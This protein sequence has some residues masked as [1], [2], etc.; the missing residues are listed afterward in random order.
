VQLVYLEVSDPAPGGESYRRKIGSKG[1]MGDAEYIKPLPLLQEVQDPQTL[2]I[3]AMETA[4]E[5]LSPAG[6]ICVCADTQNSARVRLVLDDI[7]GEGNFLNEVIWHFRKRGSSKKRFS[8]RHAALF[9]YGK[10][11]E[12]KFK[13][14]GQVR[15]REAVHH[16][17]RNID[18]EGRVYF[19]LIS[20]GKEYKYY[21]D[22]IIPFDD[23]WDIP[24]EEQNYEFALPGQKPDEL[25]KRIIFASTD[26][27][28]KVAALFAGA[29]GILLQAALNNRPF[30]GLEYNRHVLHGLRQSILSQPGIDLTIYRS[31][32]YENTAIVSLNAVNRNGDTLLMLDGY[33]HTRVK[34][35]PHYDDGREYIDYWA[36]GYIKNNI[37]TV[38]DCSFRSKS[39]PKLRQMLRIPNQSGGAAY[40]VDVLGNEKLITV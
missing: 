12:V 34:D 18:E 30:I 1:Y 28:D 39:A 20:G 10:T 19:S 17:K 31:I 26:E 14:A 11:A 9:F 36:A 38:T 5:I 24:A 32:P 16:L 4:K 6:V 3:S 15:G 33:S 22:E 2:L 8:N 40:F 23:V 37:F 27:G 25:L 13:P 35:L 29:S 7:F 21:E